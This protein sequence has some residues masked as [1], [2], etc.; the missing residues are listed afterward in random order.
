[1]RNLE[2]VL[3][4]VQLIGIEQNASGGRRTW[5]SSEAIG[6]ARDSNCP[7]FSVSYFIVVYKSVYLTCSRGL[8]KPRVPESVVNV[9]YHTITAS[10][11]ELCE[12]R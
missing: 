2:A 5:Y 7:Q 4:H 12:P 9:A 3:A 6:Y 10:L 1:V 11:R 8:H